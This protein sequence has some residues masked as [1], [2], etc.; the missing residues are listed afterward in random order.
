M[1]SKKNLKIYFF[2]VYI[3]FLNFSRFTFFLGPFHN[4]F[5]SAL[6]RREAIERINNNSSILTTNDLVPHLS[7][8][9]IKFTNAE[10]NYNLDEFDEISWIL[11]NLDGN[12]IKILL[13]TFIKIL[14]LTKDGLRNMKKIILFCSK[15]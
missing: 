2:L 10:I 1:V 3:N 7:K 11:K 12:Q 13:I 6:S 9:N 14:E 5:E 4:H 8:E 15:K